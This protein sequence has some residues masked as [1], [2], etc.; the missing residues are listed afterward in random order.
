MRT[1]GSGVC[2]I[3]IRRD[4]E[5]RVFYVASFPEAIYVLHVF[6]KKTPKT[7]FSDI[8]LGRE[9]YK[10]LIVDRRTRYEAQN[11]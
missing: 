5:W 2:E 11:D 4:G 9:R 10:R 8:Y 7:S 1:V 3:R 6:R